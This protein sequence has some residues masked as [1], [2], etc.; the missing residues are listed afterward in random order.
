MH[1]VVA[2]DVKRVACNLTV[3]VS[4]DYC[5]NPGKVILTA[6]PPSGVSYLW[7]TGETTKS[8]TVD[9]AGVYSV[10]I[11]DI[12]GCSVSDEMSVGQEL[13]TNGSFTAGNTGFTSGYVFKADSANYNKE[14]YDDSGN[15]AYGVG[16][17]GQNYHPSFWG[18]DHT[19]NSKWQ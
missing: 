18:K 6:S 8:I 9:V 16:I 13:V 19:N 15:N 7:S 10:I 2:Q 3:S 11:T 17:D 5:T 4:A 14:L 1:H 12:S